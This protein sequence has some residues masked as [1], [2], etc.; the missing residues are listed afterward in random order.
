MANATDAFELEIHDLIFTNLAFD[1]IG[2]AAGL[3]ASSSDGSM[4]AT[5]HTAA[6][7]DVS[8]QSTSEATYT[9]YA[10][11]TAN[12]QRNVSD[13]TNAAGV[14]TNDEIIT[15]GEKTGGGDETMTYMGLGSSVSAQELW[16]WAALD[17]S[18]LVSN[19]I[20]PQYIASALDITVD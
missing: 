20:N 2:S 19:G 14:I 13:W 8:I 15:F 4:E 6:L 9:G 16:F 12:T 7:T 17:S 1:N 10:R 5:L 18:L 3:V 11:N